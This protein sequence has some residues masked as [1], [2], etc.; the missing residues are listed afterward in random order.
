MTDLAKYGPWAVIAGGSEGVGAELARQLA[1]AGFNL[2]LIARKP[3][4]LTDTADQCRE[5]GV[6]VRAISVDLLEPQSVSRIAEDTADL[7]VGL[8][9]YNAGASTCNELFLDTDLSEFQ[10]V[11]DLNVTRML[12]MVQH[13]GRSMADRGRGGIMIVGSLSGYMGAWRHSIYAGAKAFSRMF[14]ESLWL[15]LRER[16]VDVLELVLGVTRTPAMERVGLNFD[17]PGILVNEPAEVAAEGL[18]HLADGP[19]WVAGGNADRAEAN[20]A[21]DRSRVVLET[22]R[23]IAALIAGA[24]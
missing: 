13:F 22:H 23:A 3:G 24:H 20:S 17:A 6:E 4:P 7:E 12:E 19:V 8:L 18:A 1:V 2:V 9:I 14:A 10:K 15:E 11:T 5:L 16:N 21:P